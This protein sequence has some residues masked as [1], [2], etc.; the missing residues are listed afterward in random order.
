MSFDDEWNQ[1]VAEADRRREARTRLES[2]GG[3]GRGGAG[4]ADADFGLEDGPVRSKVS[5]IRRATTEARSKSKL[6]DARAA[7]TSHS[8]W[9]AGA[10]GDDCVN[11][12]QRRLHG[13][14]DLVEDA[15]DAL[16]EAM[17]QQID[18]DRSTAAGLRASSRWLEGA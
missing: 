9:L 4:L 6:A 3:G 8:G 2:A 5:G 14:S 15:A 1:L 10:A 18:Q 12:W 7:G 16:T 17:D 11:A 13:L